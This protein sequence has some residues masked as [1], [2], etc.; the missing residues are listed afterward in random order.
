M[1][2]PIFNPIWF[3]LIEL[4]E[5]FGTAFVV[6]GALALIG[7]GIVIFI[8]MIEPEAIPKYIKKIAIIGAITLAIGGFIPSKET[9]YK[10]IVTSYITP[11][12]I[13]SAKGEATDLIDYIIEKVDELND[14]EESD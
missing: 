9:C 6:I 10:M 7:S 2:F 3:Y 5:R 14:N 13:E 8:C 1:N 12:N 4:F 11:A